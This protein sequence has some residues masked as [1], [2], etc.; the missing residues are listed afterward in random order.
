LIHVWRDTLKLKHWH[1][2]KSV[3]PIQAVVVGDNRLC[4][5]L[6][7]ELQAMGY[8]I[9]AIRPPTVPKLGARLRITFSANHVLED[10]QTLAQVLMDL[11]LRTMSA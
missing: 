4:V 1:M 5:R 7:Q 9:P 10:V 3:T 2:L 6:D 11:E 8:L